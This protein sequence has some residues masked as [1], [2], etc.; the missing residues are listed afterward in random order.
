MATRAHAPLAHHPGRAR[1]PGDGHGGVRRAGRGPGRGHEHDDDVGH[2]PPRRRPSRRPRRRRPSRSPG[3]TG[4]RAARA[5]RAQAPRAQARASQDR[6]ARAPRA[7]ADR[8]RAAPDRAGPGPGGGSGSKGSGNSGSKGSSG[9][10]SGGKGP[11]GPSTTAAPATQPAQVPVPTTKPT[12]EQGPR[13]EVRQGLFAQGEGQGARDASADGDHRVG[14]H[15]DRRAASAT[16]DAPVSGGTKGRRR[17]EARGRAGVPGPGLA[18]ARPAAPRPPTRRP[19]PRRR[20]RSTPP[21]CRRR[22]PHPPPTPPPRRPHPRSRQRPRQGTPPLRRRPRPVWAAA[23]RPI[24]AAPAPAAATKD[25]VAI[26]RRAHAAIHRASRSVADP[27]A[28]QPAP[29]ARFLARPF[30]PAPGAVPRREEA[31]PHHR[32]HRDR[33]HAEQVDPAAQAAMKILSPT[34]RRG[35]GRRRDDPAARAHALRERGHRP[36]PA[37]RR[38]P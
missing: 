38:R 21:A 6:A 30:A 27:A 28:R 25:V 8:D 33:P 1:D 5:R 3:A 18:P 31:R 22:P 4:D 19:P 2:Q 12:L 32:R 13:V 23:G 24:V 29:P 20:P 36:P 15:R 14:G 17:R 34:G 11:G 10:G 35:R 7:R 26:E 37:P 16:A 9:R